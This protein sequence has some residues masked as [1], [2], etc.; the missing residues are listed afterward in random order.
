MVAF[1]RGVP[2]V[3]ISQ[4]KILYLGKVAYRRWSPKRGGHTRRFNCRSKFLLG[5]YFLKESP[6]A[7]SLY[8]LLRWLDIGQ[9]LSVRDEVEVHKNA[10][11]NSNCVQT[12]DSAYSSDCRLSPD[13]KRIYDSDY[14]SDFDSVPSEMQCRSSPSRRNVDELVIL[15]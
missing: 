2:T 6:G 15:Y 5:I 3:V 4:G 1:K 8:T 10:E 14:D 9:V 13:R 7:R 12:V 11:N